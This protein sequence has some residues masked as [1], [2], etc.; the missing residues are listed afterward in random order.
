LHARSTRSAL[1]LGSLAALALACASPAPP[2]DEAFALSPIS[3]EERAMQTRVFDTDDQAA[4]LAACIEVLRS[5]AFASE[6]Q[7]DALGVIVASKDA[8]TSSGRTRLRVSLATQPAGEFGTQVALRVTF[9]RLAWN[10][11]GRET[12]REAVRAPAEYAGFFAEVERALAP[13][14]ARE[15]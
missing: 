9:Q 7:D 4:V 3:A 15:S 10:R 13:P 2:P 5:H 8:A 14:G 12:Q 11:R 1:I 6:D